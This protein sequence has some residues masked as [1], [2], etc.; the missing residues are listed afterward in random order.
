MSG[1]STNGLPLAS[2]LTG[3][4]RV[5]LDTQAASGVPPQSEAATT[6]QLG[7]AGYGYVVPTAGQSLAIPNNV[8]TYLMDPAGV[9]GTLTLTMPSAPTDGFILRIA[10]SQ[11]ITA[12]TLNGNAG[13]TIAQ[14]PTALTVSTTGP[15]GY[16]FIF[17]AATAKWYRLQ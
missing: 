1:F 10:S 4:E 11:T 6:A 17:N 15:Y 14:A 9:L 13:Q 16:E 7:I 8:N 5:A 3:V 2:S 12:L